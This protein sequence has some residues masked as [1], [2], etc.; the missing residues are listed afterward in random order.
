[1]PSLQLEAAQPS[2]ANPSSFQ[3]PN[4]Y[5]EPSGLW[6]W[7]GTSQHQPLQNPWPN[8]SQPGPHIQGD[9]LGGNFNTPNSLESFD[10][11][12]ANFQHP[13]WGS[14]Q[15]NPSGHSSNSLPQLNSWPQAFN[16]VL[17]ESHPQLQPAQN[18]PTFSSF[19]NDRTGYT[20]TMFTV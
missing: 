3:L 19:M 4:S 18:T 9:R 5:P 12:Y 20:P 10:R 7:L 2:A 17:P 8:P 1:M 13:R 11:I 14:E 16:T 15:V 6:S